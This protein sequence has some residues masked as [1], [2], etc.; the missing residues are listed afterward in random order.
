M[1]VQEQTLE[2]TRKTG[3]SLR[4]KEQSLK[5]ELREAELQEKN[6]NERLH[7]Y[8]LDKNSYLEEQQQKTARLEELENF[9]NHVKQKLKSLTD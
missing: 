5:G 2:Q 6:M 8:D 1:G 7:L 9:W 4:L 3:E